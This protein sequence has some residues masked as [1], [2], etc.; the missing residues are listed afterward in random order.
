MMPGTVSDLTVDELKQLVR[1]A[2]REALDDLLPDPDSG[3][4]LRDDVVDSLR[5]SLAQEAQGHLTRIAADQ[6]ASELGLTW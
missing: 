3:L 6:V 1:L 5:D 2:V 4:E